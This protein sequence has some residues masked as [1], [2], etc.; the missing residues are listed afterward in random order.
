MRTLALA[1]LMSSGCG[2]I[3]LDSSAPIDCSAVC[4]RVTEQLVRDFGIDPQRIH[5]EH[6]DFV[7]AHDCGTCNSVFERTFSVAVVGCSS[8]P[9][10]E[11][12]PA[13]SRPQPSPPPAR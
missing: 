6:P 9:V 10:Q 8:A 4:F 3:P 7:N 13:L 12:G 1:A 5:C 11:A 2:P